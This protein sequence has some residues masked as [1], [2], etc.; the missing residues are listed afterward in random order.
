MHQV[1]LLEVLMRRI[2]RRTSI[3]RSVQ[4]GRATSEEVAKFADQIHT[5][6]SEDSPG[7][8]TD[9]QTESTIPPENARDKPE[10]K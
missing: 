5:R 2:N 8:S 9:D 10:E 7:T 1:S 6:Q 3:A 4:R